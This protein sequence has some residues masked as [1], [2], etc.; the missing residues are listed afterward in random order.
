MPPTHAS[1]DAGFAEA[2]ALSRSI[3]LTIAHHCQDKLYPFGTSR[4][5]L[6]LLHDGALPLVILICCTGNFSRELLLGSTNRL[7]AFK[8]LPALTVWV[9]ELK[10]PA[11]IQTKAAAQGLQDPHRS[12][13]PERFAMLSPPIFAGQ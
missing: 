10:T 8:A 2:F 1:W 7:C 13:F 12:T 6:Q 11:S 5:P 4:S 3:L 9:D